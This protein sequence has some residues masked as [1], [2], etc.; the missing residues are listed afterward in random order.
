MLYIVT[1]HHAVSSLKH[2]LTIII[3]PKEEFGKGR[4]KCFVACAPTEM[5]MAQTWHSTILNFEV[6]E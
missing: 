6:M 4:E 3:S 5:F 1:K 2:L